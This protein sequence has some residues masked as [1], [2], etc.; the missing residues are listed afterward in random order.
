MPKKI[1][2]LKGEGT[3][4]SYSALNLHNGDCFVNTII[5]LF[6]IKT[7]YQVHNLH[8]CSNIH[9]FICVFIIFVCNSTILFGSSPFLY[10]NSSSSHPYVT[11]YLITT[12]HS[13]IYMLW[14]QPT[15]FSFFYILLFSLWTADTFTW[16]YVLAFLNPVYF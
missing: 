1:K 16:T 6:N 7:K 5:H 11:Y 10:F 4:D 8:S 14:F 12:Y 3:I 2:N 15:F 9:I 13:N